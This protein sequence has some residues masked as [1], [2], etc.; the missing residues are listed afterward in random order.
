MEKIFDFKKEYK[1]YYCTSKEV[2]FLKLIDVKYIIIEGHGSPDEIDGLFSKSVQ[3]LY[4][5]A[6]KL[7]MSYL[8]DYKID[9][10]FKY[11]VPPLEGLWWMEGIKGVDLSDKS[12][13][14]WII[15]QRVPEFITQKDFDWAVNNVNIKNKNEFASNLKLVSVDEG[16]CVQLLHIGPFST[17]N[18]TVD[19]LNQY[20]SENK[21]VEGFDSK[22]RMHHEIY[23]SDFRKCSQDKLKTIIRHPILFK[24]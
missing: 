12:K 9:G 16:N 11:V 10:F 21:M 23:L 7:K 3:I 5:T 4:Q 15:M 13:F 19:I 18:K 17:E 1:D 24:V 20:M 22:Y 2:K 14:Q 6:Y 8:S